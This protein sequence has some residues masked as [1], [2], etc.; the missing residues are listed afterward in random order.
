MAS[1]E[2]LCRE[3]VYGPLQKPLT[4]AFI[5]RS[6]S[7]KGT[8]AKLLMSRLHKPIYI[9]T[10][11]LFRALAGT[12]SVSGRKVAAQLKVGGLP[13]YWLAYVLWQRELVE[14]LVDGD[15]D[16]VF[17]GAL[18]RVEEITLLD[19]VLAWLERPMAIPALIDVTREEAFKRLKARKREDDTDESINNRLDYYEVDVVPVIE[20]YER[21]GRLVCVDGMPP[22]DKVFDHLLAA[23]GMK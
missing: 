6:G 17:D 10:G 21:Q 15:E 23:L 14:K 19:E 4:I 18:R 1:A 20:Y 3:I 11:N 13:P 9:A 5:G 8:Q 16:V 7:G 12:D 2:R 22:P